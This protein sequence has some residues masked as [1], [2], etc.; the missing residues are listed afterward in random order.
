MLVQNAQAERQRMM[1]LSLLV[2]LELR[3]ADLYHGV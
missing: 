3:A 1:T 2:S